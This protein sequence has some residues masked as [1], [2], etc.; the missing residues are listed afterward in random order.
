MLIL[1]LNAGS[2]SLKFNLVNMEEEK[3]LA[4]GIAER[5]GLSEGFIRWTIQGEKGRLELDMTNHKKALSTIMERLRESVLHADQDVAAIGHRVVHG[6][7]N[8]SASELITPPVLAE[9]EASSFYAPLHNPPA[10]SGIRTAQEVFPGVPQ[11]A[12]FDTAFH[13]DMPA[14]AYTYGL[15]YELSERLGLR[16]YGFHGTSH[17]YVAERTAALIGKPLRESRI[18]TCHLGNGSSITAVHNGRSVDTS[19]GL[20]PLEGVVMGTRSGSIDPGVLTC[21][22]E[23]EKMDGPALASL[24]NKKSGLLGVSGVSSDCREIEEVMDHNPRARLAHEMLAYG[25]L[26]YVGAYA[27]A[28]NGVDAITFTAGIG[29]NSAPLRSWVCQRLGFLGVE[30]D[31]TANHTRSKADRTISTPGSRIPVAVI[32]TNEELMIA[33]EARRVT[34]GHQVA[35]V[36]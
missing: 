36:I 19:M 24:L 4:E 30:L 5:I 20:T 13:H 32:P 16:R 27:A 22:L 29:E 12:V 25:V 2:S 17:Q 26:K 31:E 33:R 34:L 3:T 11:V 15:P 1:V 28:M 14:Y 35:S 10:I 21:L 18:I 6:G 8:F 9:I 23:Q 7:P